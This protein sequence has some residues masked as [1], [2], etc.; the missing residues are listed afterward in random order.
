MPRQGKTGVSLSP[1][2]PADERILAP[3]F[4]VRAQRCALSFQVIVNSVIVN[5]TPG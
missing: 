2:P 1:T 5:Q 3:H 4:P